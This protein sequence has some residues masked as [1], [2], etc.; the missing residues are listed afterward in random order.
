MKLFL[1]YLSQI[2]K[3]I[4][5]Y[6]TFGIIFAITFLL[7]HLPLEAVLYPA[8]LCVIVGVGYIIQGYMHIRRRHNELQE[9]HKVTATM[10]N[11]FPTAVGI[12]DADYQEIIHLLLEEKAHL[13]TMMNNRYTDMIDYYT[14]W[15]H[16]IK[17]P[18]ATMRLT[19]QNEDT[20]FSRKLM[21]ELFRI[22][23][24]VEMV[25]AFLRLGSVTNDFL[26]KEYELDAMIRQAVKKYSGEFIERKIRLDYKP[27]AIVVVTD[28]KWFS[29]VLEQLLSN[30]LKYT[31]QGCISIYLKES[32]ILC[33][34]DTGIGIAAEDLPRIFDKGYTGYNGRCDK[35]ATGLGLYLCKTICR[36]LEHTITAT[37]SLGQGTIVQIDLNQYHLSKE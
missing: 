13:E 14:V 15:V 6:L 19:L 3:G 25:L 7:Y 10:I 33:I 27:T 34:K 16:Q 18:I 31:R 26:I 22:E 24:Y 5:L 32:H 2:R 8:G 12:E 17:T 30:A 9:L 20:E 11:R 23:Q 36:K 21:V 37:S 29:F 4:L 28:E 1:L 35:K